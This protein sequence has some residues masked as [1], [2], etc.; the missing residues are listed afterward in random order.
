ME[1][2]LKGGADDGLGGGVIE[3]W[4]DRRTCTNV[5]GEGFCII[6]ATSLRWL[7]Q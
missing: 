5:E 4:M 7:S 6:I 2:G 3:R 1:E